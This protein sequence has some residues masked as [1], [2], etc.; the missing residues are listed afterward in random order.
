[1]QIRRYVGNDLPQVL[2]QVNRELGPNAVILNTRKTHQGGFFGILGRQAVE[3]TVAVDYD[4]RLSQD[5]APSRQPAPQRPIYSPPARRSQRG[6][7]STAARRELNEMRIKPRGTAAASVEPQQNFPEELERVHRL[8]VKNQVEV[9]ISRQMLRVF[10]EQLALLGEDWK[11]AQPRFEQYVTGMIRTRQGIQLREGR[12]PLVAMFI[13]PTGVGKT[14][15]LAKI[16]SAFTL[17]EHRRVGIITADT[18]RLGATDQMCRYGEILGIPVKIV[19]TPQEM[20]QAVLSFSGYDLLLVDTAGRSPQ[21]KEQ[22]LQMKQIVEAA[23]PDE[24]H[25]VVSMTTKYVDVI[26]ILSR[27][28][29]VPINR[30]TLTKLDETRTFGLLLNISMK[31]GMDIAYITTGQQVPDD[32]EAAEPSRLAKLV[33]NG[34]GGENGRPSF[35]AA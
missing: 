19:E 18:Y 7:Q 13:G 12:K 30:V 2:A 9:D 6:D 4:F 15:T 32:L 17:R 16:A 5:S 21:N 14:T 29:L 23:R 1:M 24:I 10:D 26:S 35:P 34:I 22:I 25:L 31:F 8:L 28:G 20:E 11:R 33:L 3:V 27:F